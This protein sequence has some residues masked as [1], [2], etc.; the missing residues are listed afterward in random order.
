MESVASPTVIMSIVIKLQLSKRL[1]AVR[2][3]GRAGWEAYGERA[4]V[5][6]TCAQRQRWKRLR[7]RTSPPQSLLQ[8]AAVMQ[9][10]LESGC[11]CY[12]STFEWCL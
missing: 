10:S 5:R 12:A 9:S 3:R 7:S 6:S 11:K 8:R 1:L 2:R 4:R